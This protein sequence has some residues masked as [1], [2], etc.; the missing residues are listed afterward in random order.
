MEHRQSTTL[1]PP[2]EDHDMPRTAPL[3]VVVDA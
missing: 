2:T 3:T 1:N